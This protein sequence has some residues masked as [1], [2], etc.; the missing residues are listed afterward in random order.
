MSD[1]SQY[2]I[3][4]LTSIYTLSLPFKEDGMKLLVAPAAAGLTIYVLTLIYTKIFG[5]D[6][7]ILWWLRKN[8]VIIDEKNPAY[9]KI[10][11]YFYDKYNT[12]IYGCKLDADYGGKKVFIEKIKQSKFTEKYVCDSKTYDIIIKLGSSKDKNSNDNK[13]SVFAE[14]EIILESKC[15]TKVI[16][17]YIVHLVKISNNQNINRIHTYKLYATT[18]K[19]DGRELTWKEIVSRSSKNR[20]NTIVS[21]KVNKRFFDDIDK[22]MDNESNYIAKGLSYKRG[23]VLWGEPGCG[24]TSIVKTV[25]SEFRLPIFAVDLTII[26]TNNE[27][28]KA[29]A[30]ISNYVSGDQKYILLFE[31]LDR[32]KMFKKDRYGNS[33]Y[34][35]NLTEDC[36]LNIL[37]GVDETYGRITIMTCNDITPIKSVPALTRPGRIDTIVNI[38]KCTKDQMDGIIR[39]H[40]DH[41]GTIELKDII[42]I[43]PAQLIQLITKINDIQKIINLLNKILDFTKIDINEL[44]NT[45]SSDNTKSTTTGKSK[46]NQTGS[47]NS[48]SGQPELH[49]KER[50]LKRMMTVLKKAQID[51]DM[52]QQ[53]LDPS[54]EIDDLTLEAKRIAIRK[55]EIAIKEKKEKYIKYKKRRQV[56]ITR[57]DIGIYEDIK[58][59]MDNTQLEKA[60]LEERK[61]DTLKD[62]PTTNVIPLTTQV[63]LGMIVK[64]KVGR[65]YNFVKAPTVNNVDDNDENN[66][67]DTDSE[68]VSNE[69]DKIIIINDFVTKTE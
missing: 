10:V 58:S 17:K 21:S 45:S 1:I 32:C 64:D 55:K 53:T 69:D 42:E 7:T 31:D 28:C 37:D 57:K 41:T 34:H 54:K 23:Y 51:Y 18:K 39:L 11:R 2:L 24:K 33:Y 35:S 3:T 12:L 56:N 9:D 4:I 22:F 52:M 62:N 5:T 36:L 6:L 40:M 65:G 47:S 38:T 14:R 27:L 20:S 30:D 46:S 19:D 15:S 60:D 59:I 67:D 16:E 49:W 43:T 63:Q 13:K 29:C 68:T 66:M 50:V 8:Y 26:D 61:N 25:A 44:D 48:S